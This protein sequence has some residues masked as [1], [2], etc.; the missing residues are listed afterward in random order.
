MHPRHAPQFVLALVI[1]GGS[2]YREL[3]HL[4]HAAIAG[5]G[6]ASATGEDGIWSLATGLAVVEAAKTG[7]SVA[8]EPGF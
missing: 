7:G 4:A 2:G 6:T 8:V 5:K 3:L 1:A